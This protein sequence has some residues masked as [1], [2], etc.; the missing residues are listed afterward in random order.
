[1]NKSSIS[2]A[3]QGRAKT[4]AEEREVLKE[5]EQTW[6]N[7]QETLETNLPK[8]L[9]DKARELMN[10]ELMKVEEELKVRDVLQNREVQ[11]D[12]EK[13][14]WDNISQSLKETETELTLAEK[15]LIDKQVEK[16]K[17]DLNEVNRRLDEMDMIKGDSNSIKQI[18]G[19]LEDSFWKD[20]LRLSLH[21]GARAEKGGTTTTHHIRPR[22]SRPSG[23]DTLEYFATIGE[24]ATEVLFG[25]PFEAVLD[26]LNP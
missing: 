7:L 17:K 13:K 18:R 12:E 24:D 9:R 11:L 3:G 16:V 2:W 10:T 26:T 8:Q 15:Q 20:K 19:V 22:T 23:L 1:M 5:D 4:A 14:T 21:V 25:V 6:R